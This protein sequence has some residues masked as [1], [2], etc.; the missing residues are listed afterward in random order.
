MS[1]ST[2]VVIAAVVLA[3]VYG[4]LLGLIYD[5]VRTIQRDVEWLCGR[6]ER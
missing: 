1:T 2:V 4:G 5:S 3:L 6:G